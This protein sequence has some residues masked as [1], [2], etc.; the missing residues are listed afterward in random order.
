MRYTKGF[1]FIYFIIPIFSCNNSNP[2]VITNREPI[3][4]TDDLITNLPGSLCLCDDY[5]I[6]GNPFSEEYF[7]NIID[8]TTGKELGAFGNV[9]RGPQEFLHPTLVNC[10]DNELLVYDINS[11]QRSI[12][13]IQNFLNGENYVSEMTADE[14]NLI[15]MSTRL[16]TITN[17]SYL[18][19]SPDNELI[20]KYVKDGKAIHFGPKPFGENV[21]IDNSWDVMQGNIAYCPNRKLLVYAAIG[22]PY[23]AIFQ[24]DDSGFHLIHENHGMHKYKQSQNDIILDNSKLG[25]LEMILTKDYIVTLQRDYNYDPV[26][27]SSIGRDASK[28]P[29]TVFLYDY[30]GNLKEVVCLGKNV[31]RIAADNNENIL[32]TIIVD[33]DFKIAK[34]NL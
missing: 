27:E 2:P 9:G 26:D 1:I 22:F 28:I 34:Y 12:L 6:W 10:K 31:C 18:L 7:A 30:M 23:L 8:R 33:D 29:T 32:Y 15:S 3:V 13:S 17:D 20:F 24:H 14:N 11:G 25:S 21:M 19:L 4:L 5:L 16:L